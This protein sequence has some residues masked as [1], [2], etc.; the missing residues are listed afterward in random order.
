MAVKRDSVNRAYVNASGDC[1]FIVVPL[2]RVSG[3]HRKRPGDHITLTEVE[4]LDIF[5]GVEK[6]AMAYGGQGN[7]TKTITATGDAVF[8]P[9]AEGAEDTVF[10]PML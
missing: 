3:L 6:D 5:P 1:G 10:D 7:P 2:S 8:D 4:E 9:M